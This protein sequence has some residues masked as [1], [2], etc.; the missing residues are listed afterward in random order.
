MR[1]LKT[2]LGFTL[3]LSLSAVLS[4]GQVY[5][6]IVADGLPAYVGSVSVHWPCCG[7]LRR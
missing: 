1:S 4:A 2:A 5:G 3:A 6:T 7:T